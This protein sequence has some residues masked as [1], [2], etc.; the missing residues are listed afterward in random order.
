MKKLFSFACAC[1]I[2]L[3]LP[4]CNQPAEF[5]KDKET[6]ANKVK[7]TIAELTTISETTYPMTTSVDYSTLTNDEYAKQLAKD[8]TT[9]D[10]TLKSEKYDDELYFL[11]TDDTSDININ[12]CFSK[13][14]NHI[15][16]L[17]NT[18]GGED[19]CYYV[20]Q[21]ALDCDLFAIDLSDQIDILAHYMVDEIDYNKNGIKISETKKGN[22]IVI[23][24]RL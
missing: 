4:A 11:K 2:I 6:T 22:T 18:D 1:F 5:S 20:L 17:F 8:F 7:D 12:V 10:V 21:K 14:G 13:F 9:K 19:E 23:G 24:F 15:E 3:S 16:L